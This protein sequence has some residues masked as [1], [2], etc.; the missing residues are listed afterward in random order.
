MV[1]KKINIRNKGRAAEQEVAT[2]LREIVKTL[3]LNNNHGCEIEEQLSRAVTRNQNQSAVGGCDIDVFGLSIEV[4]R[5]ETLCLKSWWSQA[6]ISAART[7]QLPVLIWRQNRQPWRA[8][9]PGQLPTYYQ[10]AQPVSATVIIEIDDFRNWFY[11]WVENY[12]RVTL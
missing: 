5:Q 9:L 1:D 2:M 3:I 4:K 12:I 11:S 10:G 7:Q 6:V 8:M